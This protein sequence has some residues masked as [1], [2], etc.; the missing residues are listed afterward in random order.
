MS[1][2]KIDVDEELLCTTCFQLVNNATQTP[3][4]G[5]L[6][7]RSCI[8]PWTNRHSSCPCCRKIICSNQLIADVRS[9][10]KSSV[11]RRCCK[12]SDFGCEFMGGRTETT[13]HEQICR[14][15]PE[16]LRT[17]I[18]DLTLELSEAKKKI[19]RLE[20]ENERQVSSRKL[21]DTKKEWLK[22]VLGK[23][24]GLNVVK[25]FLS[26][27]ARSPEV[28]T[29]NFECNKSSYQVVITVANFNVSAMLFYRDALEMQRNHKFT[30]KVVLIHPDGPQLNKS[31]TITA[32]FKKDQSLV[33][34]GNGN[35]MTAAEF[36]K[37]FKNDMFAFGV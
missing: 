13:A 19:S 34:H 5:A 1:K 10:R 2:R 6:F 31:T 24:V 35:W 29:L 21:Q 32:N 20:A 26:A 22:K 3:C 9:E 12:N 37:F 8:E 25:V 27:P 23:T 33:G 15:Q 36:G 7:C 17:K 11:H 16:L 28:Y 18:N 14:I 4:C 30:V